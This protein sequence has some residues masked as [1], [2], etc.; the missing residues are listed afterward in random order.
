MTF[1]N[2]SVVEFLHCGC[3]HR[4]K[5]TRYTCTVAIDLNLTL[6]DILMVDEDAGRSTVDS[7]AI[8]EVNKTVRVK[9]IGEGSLKEGGTDRCHCQGPTIPPSPCWLKVIGK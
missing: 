3:F 7:S 1:L 8:D 6:S 9:V 5:I 4:S 2:I